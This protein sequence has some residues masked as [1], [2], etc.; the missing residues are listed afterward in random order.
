MR[1]DFYLR[2]QTLFGQALAVLGNIP[3]LGSNNPEKA[4]SL[5]FFNEEFWRL[6]IEV[7]SDN[8][9]TLHY[10]YIFTDE[11]GMAHREAEKHRQVNLNK[12]SSD[13]VLIDSWNDE[14][15]I[16]NAFFTT[17]FSEVYFHHK[18]KH[19]SK[20]S[21][22]FTHQ[23]KIKAPL[24]KE[25]EA[26]FIAG[27]T[28]ALNQWA[29]AS[30]VLLQRKGEWWMLETDLSETNFPISYKYGITNLK[31]P[32]QYRFE[33]GDNRILH[34]DIPADKQTIVHDGFIK[35][36]GLSWKGAGVA[37][38][39]FSL[40]SSSSFGVG[41]FTDI[42]LL[43]DWAV[44]TNLKLIQLLPVNDTSATYT[45]KDSYPYAA[46]SAFALHPI[47]I[48]LQKVAGKKN[49]QSLK[50]LSRKQKQLNA[51]ADLDYEQ[52]IQFKINVLRELYE[53]DDM[54]FLEDREF[55]SFFEDNKN[56][57]VPYAA[58]CFLRDR[59]GTADYSKWKTH[60]IYNEEEVGRLVSKRSRQYRPVNFFYFVQY[61]LH[62]Q[63]KEAVDYAH[64]KGI[65]I[66]GDIPIG[67]YRFGADAWT[68]PSLYNMDMQAGAPPDDFAVKGQNWGFPTYNW[69]K[70][71]E[72][73]FEWWHQ[74]FHQM[75][76][77]FDAF[78]IDHI[79]GFFRIWSIPL[80]AV[81]GILGRFIPALP[82]HVNEFGEWG[83]WFDHQRYCTPFIN[84]DVLHQLFGEHALFVQSHF[85]DQTENGFV[86]KEQVNTQ[87]K[88]EAYF[89]SQD[90]SE[91]NEV[92]RQGL[93]DLIANVILIEEPGTDGTGFHFRISM[94][95][96]TSFQHLDDSTKVK[97]KELYVNYFYKRQDDFWK[98][99]A[100]KKLP[101]LK[102]A[103]NML[104]CGED[105]GMVPHSVPEVME[106]LG[107]LSLEIQRMPKNP[108]TEFFHPKDAPYL[109]VIT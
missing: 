40:R 81:E 51:L 21:G 15:Y 18:G 75:S 68:A 96:T 24:L 53:L 72:D 23:L 20:K 49:I 56:W 97:L 67:I 59:Y 88:V 36:P 6:S 86:L 69:K 100:M 89:D 104:V 47:Y 26:V 71:E 103:T 12:I 29:A 39:V 91:G 3:E 1:I 106:Q 5:E 42:R 10:H 63:L 54:A 109:S 98:K 79:L 85:L 31:D 60:S 4:V 73:H 77:Y 94:E 55:K 58:F 32:D 52:V 7:E 44:K 11:K 25:D 108:A 82:V 90:V 38:P 22:T 83:I 102:E 28:D 37:I 13:L 99:E 84:D 105:L 2:F 65:A 70:M 16:E 48:N 107:I 30:P 35:L 78:R 80:H 64:K 8:M 92:I 34:Y 95:T 87:R 43:V 46:I 57:L 33:S 66:K 50:S 62:L 19:K 93:Y 74:R 76:N 14:S 45:L 101:A 9:H 41:E 17:P 27:N 61:H